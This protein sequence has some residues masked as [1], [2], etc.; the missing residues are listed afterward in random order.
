[1]KRIWVRGFF[2][3]LSLL[4]SACSSM[5]TSS[6]DASGRSNRAEG[7]K[8]VSGQRDPASIECPTSFYNHGIEYDQILR[9]KVESVNTGPGPLKISNCQLRN[10]SVNA[11]ANVFMPLPGD[12]DP[13]SLYRTLGIE[14]VRVYSCSTNTNSEKQAYIQVVHFQ[15]IEDTIKDRSREAVAN[16]CSARTPSYPFISA[17]LTTRY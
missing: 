7:Q 5:G 10:N 1:M 2:S 6:V 9:E 17:T 8:N 14:T 16:K 4:L 12:M 13:R 11:N 3:L 15:P